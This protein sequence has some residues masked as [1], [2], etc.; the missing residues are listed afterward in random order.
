MWKGHQ[1]QVKFLGVI[2][3]R[4]LNWK[5]HI[6]YVVDRCKKVLNVMRSLTGQRWGA[7][8]RSLLMI[9]RA[10]IRSKMDYACQAYD[11]AIT[12]SIIGLTC[13]ITPNRNSTKFRRQH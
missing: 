7:D 12:G 2:F 4:K 3:D 5:A 10:L 1:H 13:I 11:T 8:K 6:G 9:Y